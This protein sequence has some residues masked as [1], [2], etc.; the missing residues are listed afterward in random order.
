VEFHWVIRIY[1]HAA[2]TERFVASI[3]LRVNQK[4]QTSFLLIKTR[5]QMQ[6]LKC[7]QRVKIWDILGHCVSG[8]NI[9]QKNPLCARQ[10]GF[11]EN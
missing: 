11:V 5:K 9:A 10:R 2:K 8:P 4:Q 6:T 3:T 1:G 7:K